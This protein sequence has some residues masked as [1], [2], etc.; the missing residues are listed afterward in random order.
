MTKGDKFE[1]GDKKKE[2]E[3]EWII[4]LAKPTI[5]VLV[6]KDN[7]SF[8]VAVGLSLSI[9]SMIHYPEELFNTNF[10]I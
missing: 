10:I 1:G 7:A 3:I 2:W 9:P 5:T 4:Q 8:G 6:D